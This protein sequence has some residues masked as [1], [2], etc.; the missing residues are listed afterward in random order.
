MRIA[1]IAEG[2]GPNACYRVFGPAA[3][4]REQG[5][6]VFS[7]VFA[8]MRDPN[9]LLTFDVVYGWRMHD[10]FFTR[11]A[12][13][14]GE[15]RIGFVWDN[16]DNFDAI[17]AKGRPNQKLFSSLRGRRIVANMTALMRMADF[18]TTPSAGL[19]EHYRGAVQTEVRVI[20]NFIDA[21]TPRDAPSRSEVVVGW[22]A[23]AEHRTDVERLGLRE[24]FQRVLD[25]HPNVHL[26]SIGCGLGL[27]SERYHHVREVPFHELRSAI[28]SFDVGIAPIADSAFNRSRS[29]VKVKEYAALGVPWLASPIGPYAG[30]GADEGG[31]LVADDRWFEE[32]GRFVGDARGRRKLAKKALKWAQRQTIE[33]NAHLWETTLRDAARLAGRGV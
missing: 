10:E 2:D 3:V 23:N 29:N 30:L 1:M 33:E 11:I 7:S 13:R 25:H 28:A 9:T 12:K 8:E 24:T 14:L 17:D 5:H 22:V 32:L 18:V 26:V 16:D 6:H 4:L 20:E 27:N 15:R 19:A 21:P 31:R